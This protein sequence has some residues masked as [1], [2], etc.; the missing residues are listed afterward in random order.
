LVSFFFWQI[1]RIVPRIGV[2]Q[3]RFIIK[4]LYFYVQHSRLS[5]KYEYKNLKNYECDFHGMNLKKNELVAY[6]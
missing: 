6:G 4:E 5:Q 2:H 3:T 1:K